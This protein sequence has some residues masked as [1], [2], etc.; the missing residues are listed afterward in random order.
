VYDLNPGN[1]LINRAFILFSYGLIGIRCL[2]AF[3]FGYAVPTGFQEVGLN[4]TQVISMLSC[5]VRWYPG[6]AGILFRELS[7]IVNNF[8][9]YRVY[10]TEWIIEVFYHT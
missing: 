1:W 9:L 8:C 3:S 4:N 6:T 7:T 2:L 5:R 10:N